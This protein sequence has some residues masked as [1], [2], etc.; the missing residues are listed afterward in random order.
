MREATGEKYLCSNEVIEFFNLSTCNWDRRRATS[1]SPSDVP[2]PC[3]DARVAVVR[4]R[5]IYQFGGVHRS[6]DGR[7]FYSSDLYKL[8]GLTL[9]WRRILLRDQ[10]TRPA[11]RMQQGL[12][13]LGKKGDEHLVMIGGCG[14]KNQ[15]ITHPTN[16][17]FGWNNEVWLFSLQKS[18]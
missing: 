3:G 11:G 12:C 6:S 14:T 2:Q 1:N 16:P 10:S 13:V 5:D 4:N 15:S 8:D 18:E 9:E 17:D 7:P